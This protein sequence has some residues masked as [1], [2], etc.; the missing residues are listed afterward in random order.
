[1]PNHNN[2]R[3]DM[4]PQQPPDDGY[5]A[6]LNA[7]RNLT[8]GKTYVPKSDN[9][10]AISMLVSVTEILK[11]IEYDDPVAIDRGLTG[12]KKNME[13]F[14]KVFHDNLIHECYS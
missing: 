4:F 10:G 5:I 9:L 13:S 3:N 11:A 2:D 7:L 6:F 8:P 1:M 12:L 14:E